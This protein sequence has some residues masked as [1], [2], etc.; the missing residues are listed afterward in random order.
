MASESFTSLIDLGLYLNTR[1]CYCVEFRFQ[2]SNFCR[3]PSNKALKS[4]LV[5]QQKSDRCPFAWSGASTASFRYDFFILL[6][7]VALDGL[8]DDSLGNFGV[9]NLG[10]T[11]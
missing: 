3:E 9:A 7:L 2:H 4:P 11:D 5:R 1:I 8:G 10:Y 6:L